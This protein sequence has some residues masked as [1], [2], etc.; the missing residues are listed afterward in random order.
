MVDANNVISTI[1]YEDGSVASIIYTTI[2]NGSYSKERIE[3]F[4]DGGVIT[5][6]EFKELT[7]VGLEGKS[8]KLKRI[9]KGQFELIKEY[10]KLVKD[11]RRNIDLPSVVDGI[12]AT[13]CSLKVLDAL[14]TGKV[15]MWGYVF[16]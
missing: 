1:R 4:V 6:D 14:K 15:Q 7:V 9:E 5:I 2:G 16:S 8:E 11:E 12:E 10:G 3:I 13:I